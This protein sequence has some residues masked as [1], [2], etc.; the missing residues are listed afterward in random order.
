L[1]I[2][3]VSLVAILD[4]DKEGFLRS[5]RS[6]IQTMGRAARNENG[7]V[8]MYAD[9]ITDSM[10]VAIDETNRRRELQQA[11]NEKHDITPVTINKE[12]R[13]LI[14]ATVAAEEEAAYGD[15]KLATY[16]KLNKKEKAEMIDQLEEEMRHAA[17][18]LDFERATELRDIIF[19]LKVEN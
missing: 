19:E 12:I 1:D 8:I 15:E 17:K 11:F 16:S 5:E 18:Q 14:R 13:G 6:L 3:E 7:Q 2:P 10:Q 4:A 9:R